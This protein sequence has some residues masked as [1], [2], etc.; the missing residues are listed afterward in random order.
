VPLTG[1]SV[2]V[3][4]PAADARYPGNGGADLIVVISVLRRIK[5]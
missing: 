5:K 1:D 3:D 2:A 4:H